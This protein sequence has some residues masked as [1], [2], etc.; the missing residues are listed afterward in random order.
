MRYFAYFIRTL[1][2]LFCLQCVQSVALAKV[3]ASESTWLQSADPASMDIYLITVGLG[4]SLDSRFGHTIL[5]FVDRQSGRDRVMNWGTFDFSD[6]WFYVNFVRGK[7]RYWLSVDN[8]QDF[9]T[10]YGHHY[11]RNVFQEKL[12]LNLAQK[13]ILTQ[14]VAENLKEENVYF[15]YDFFFNNCSTIPRDLINKALSGQIEIFAKQ[16]P[17]EKNLRAYVRENLNYP[18]PLAWMLD[19]LLNSRVDV[20]VTWWEEMF[21]PAKLREYLLAFRVKAS[22]PSGEA[23]LLSST[24]V[25]VQGQPFPPH[26]STL[27]P[28]LTFSGLVL[29]MLVFFLMRKSETRWMARWLFIPLSLFWG[30]VSVILSLLMLLGWLASEHKLLYHNP[31]LLLFWPTDL[32]WVFSAFHFGGKRRSKGQ[33]DF[34][35]SLHRL[36]ISYSSLHL[37]AVAIFLGLFFINY[38]DQNLIRTVLYIVPIHLFFLLLHRIR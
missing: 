7:M 4:P 9:L 5:R 12:E 17:A 29:S 11:G 19:I 27:Y 30:L 21:Y 26:D 18:D 20:P 13:L 1:S 10:W 25:L 33:F 14:A 2:V 31:H 36:L 35:H 38:F 22:S 15:W 24:E 37:V 23:P 34:R 8:T 28:Y 32:I 16:H 3:S 6:P